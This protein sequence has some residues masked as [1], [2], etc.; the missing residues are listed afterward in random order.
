MKIVENLSALALRQLIDGASAGNDAAEGADLI[1][2]QLDSHGERLRQVLTTTC[3]HTWKALELALAGPAWWESSRGRLSADEQAG[4][5]AKLQ[6]FFG[7]DLLGDAAN[8][9][10]EAL[11][12]LRK[13][14]QEQRLT[15]DV[16]PAAA[17][18]RAALEEPAA[19]EACIA[20]ELHGFRAL[21]EL[22]RRRPGLSRI[23]RVC[24]WQALQTDPHLSPL[25]EMLSVTKPERAAAEA[26]PGLLSDVGRLSEWREDAAEST[27]GLDLIAEIEG[28][29]RSALE[30]IAQ[31]GQAIVRGLR[32]YHLADHPLHAKDFLAIAATEER[33]RIKEL[34]ARVHALSEEEQ[35]RFPALLHGLALLEA[36]A[37]FVDGAQS[38]L[39][40]AAG[41]NG[42]PQARASACRDAFRVALEQHN[43]Q[44]ALALLQQAVALAGKTAALIPSDKFEPERILASEPTGVVFLCKHRPSGSRVV[45]RALCPEALASE[46]NELYR[47]WRVLDELDHPLL[48]RLRDA[49]FS[50]EAKRRPYVATDYFEGISLADYVRQHG[51]LLPAELARLAR[52]LAELLAGTHSRGIVHRDLRPSN[53]MLRK[54]GS[55]WRAKLIGFGLALRPAV[56]Y[57]AMAGPSTWARTTLGAAVLGTLPYLAAEQLGLSEGVTP[58]VAADVYSFGRLCYFALL[59]T[60]EPDD[61]EKESLPLPWR[62][63]L[64]TCTARSVVRRVPNF[65][66]VLKRLS[67]IPLSTAEAETPGAPAAV[68][69]PKADPQVL[70]TFLNR[71]MAFRQQG[72]YDRALA[73]FTKALQLDPRLAPAYIKRGN[74]YLDKNDLDHAIADYSAALRIDP[75]NAA[76]FM[77]R[78]LAHTKKG[79]YDAVI[80]DCTEAVRLDPKLAAAYSI[81]AAALWERGDRHRA[82]ADY[83]LALRND[84]KNALAY[85]GRGLAYA[86]EGDLDHAI[87]DYTQAIKNEPRLVL[88]YVNRGNAL[89]AKKQYDQAVA[90]FTRALRVEP[91]NSMA[92][93]NRGLALLAK[94]AYAQAAKDFSRVLQLEP[95]HAD[96]AARREE[97][98]RG[99]ATAGPAPVRPAAKA[100]ERPATQPASAN[101]GAAR[102]AKERSAP[103]VGKRR[104]GEAPTPAPQRPSRAPADQAEEERRQMRA[105]AYFAS[106]RTAYDQEKYT[107]A[108]E[109]FSK[110]LQV[111]PQDPLIFYHRGLAYVAQDDFAEA[112]A[113]FTETLKLN[114]KNPMAHYHRGI[115]HRLLGQHDQAIEDYTRALKLDPRLALA[116][117]NRSLAYAAKGDSVRAKADFDRALRLDPT[118]AQE[119]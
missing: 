73:A 38:D 54:E 1:R 65:P 71:G 9:S 106:G 101:T 53:L 44:A 100:G 63:L 28:E 111:D 34:A 70:Q 33:Q 11:R 31:F 64:S 55:D 15:G 16:N 27:P 104:S 2:Q 102:A 112:L 6:A 20:E 116:Y 48:V 19:A 96:A 80:A 98:L 118:L 83:N 58:G 37:G 45:V 86:E 41:V 13:A 30:P 42:T 84:P 78:G 35:R 17:L 92:Y 23:V 25:A 62:K 91:R 47:E 90:D 93:Y 21:A 59:G 87:S 24:L 56:L 51:P 5:A 74:T 94:H 105:A 75:K 14:H 29:T 3:Q 76:A 119:E 12:E 88:A 107:Q 50:D 61:D 7:A 68:G 8:Q 85:N 57:S 22:L 72:N 26:L 114:P 60:P 32:R 69:Q 95:R 66:T 115:A 103:A 40:T 109:Q 117:R 52:P 46:V 43:F 97:A 82:I 18:D 110:A 4:L 36:A 67:Q 99:Q 89:R 49:D 77:N 81:R 79:A 108:I 39:L 10:L 113:D